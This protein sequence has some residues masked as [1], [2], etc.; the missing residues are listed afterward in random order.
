[1]GFRIYC[2]F[3]GLLDGRVTHPITQ[4]PQGGFCVFG[5]RKIKPTTYQTN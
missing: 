4:P 2:I 3:G 1:M 5:E